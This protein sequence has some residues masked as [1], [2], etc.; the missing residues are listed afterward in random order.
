MKALEVTNLKKVYP[1]FTLDSVSFCVEEGHILGLIGA[2]GAGK[3]TT[4]KGI[5]GLIQAEGGA[6]I[7]THDAKSG[8]AKELIG[9][10]GGGFRQYPLKSVGAIARVVSG[11]YANWSDEKFKR[12]CNQFELLPDKKI[13]QL[14]EG[15]KVKFSL[16]LALSHRAKLLVLD[17]PTSGLDP[18]AREEFLDIL[19]SLVQEEGVSVLFSTHIVSDLERAADDVVLLSHGRVMIN[20]PL[21]TLKEK[22]SLAFFAEPQA[23]VVGLKAVKGGY[24][25]LILRTEHFEGATLTEPTLEEIV[26]HLERRGEV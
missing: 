7:F 20:E 19:R 23:G 13:S 3:S 1:A 25:G 21:K 2:N 6:T 4:L 12:Y 14:S 22:Y 15:M 9:Y 17:E 26:I 5:L 11:F 10:A 24:E 16:A 8:K 18:F